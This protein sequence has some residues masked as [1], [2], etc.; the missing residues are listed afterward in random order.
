[1]DQD[2]KES[3]KAP[4]P[5]TTPRGSGLAVAAD[6]PP[7]APATDDIDPAMTAS[8]LFM[9]WALGI[10][11]FWFIVKM[12]LEAATWRQFFVAL[13]FAIFTS[14]ARKRRSGEFP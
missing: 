3:P 1:M 12:R 2:S 8:L 6:L 10:V 7:Q 5:R 11:F 9:P 13:L 14:P 4:A